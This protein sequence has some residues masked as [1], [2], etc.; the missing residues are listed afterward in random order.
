MIQK[1]TVIF[2][3]TSSQSKFV[4]VRD[5]KDKDYNLENK[6]INIVKFSNEAIANLTPR[7]HFEFYTIKSFYNR[8]RPDII[9]SAEPNNFNSNEIQFEQIEPIYFKRLI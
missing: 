3:L 9:S 7:A 2:N 6:K 5:E 4:F 1:D 8:C